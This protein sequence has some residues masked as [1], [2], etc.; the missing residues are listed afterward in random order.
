MCP[1]VSCSTVDGVE[2][3]R[4][5]NADDFEPCFFSYFGESFCFDL[6]RHCIALWLVFAA[7]RERREGA[8]GREGVASRE[9]KDERCA[10]GMQ[11]MARQGTNRT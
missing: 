9:R 2:D 5:R 7:E 3:E 4:S 10:L 1:F 8:V 6:M 11:W